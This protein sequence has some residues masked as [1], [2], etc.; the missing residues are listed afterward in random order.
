MSSG[1]RMTDQ[2]VA[3]LLGAAPRSLVIADIGAAFFGETPP[4]QP[5]MDLALARLFAIDADPR[6]S[7]RLRAHWG[8][9]AEVVACAVGDGRYHTLYI[10]PEGSGMTSLLEPDPE[11]L[12]FF[13]WFPRFGAVERTEQIATR[14]LDD[15]WDVPQIDFL[16]MD[17]QGAELMVLRNGWSKLADCVAIQ[18]EVSFITL[19]KGQPTFAA[20]DI[21][22]RQHG[23]IPHR[24]RQVKPWS[25]APTM[26]NNDPRLPFHQL[27]EG[28]IVYI[29]DLIHPASMTS[30]QIA[31][32]A[33]M[34]HY[35]FNSPDLAARC[36]LNLQARGKLPEGTIDRYYGFVR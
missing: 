27:L 14:R 6:H 30:E 33:L 15:L 5:L 4:Y 28:D 12:A 26:R 8:E 34:A 32:L 9:A 31:R 23:F 11:A 13:N 18:T 19:Y 1:A 21:E 25:I 16:K 24:F 17:I 22:L 7:E 10:C 2:S 3:E 29:R 20:V 35:M 36:I